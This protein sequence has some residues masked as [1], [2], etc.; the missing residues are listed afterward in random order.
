MEKYVFADGHETPYISSRQN[1]R[2]TSAAKLSDKK[3]R[4]ISGR[5]LCEGVKLTL[6]AAKYGRLCEVYV[7]ESDAE[8][9]RDAVSSAEVAGCEVFVLS[10]PA[11]DK[12]TTEK[13]PQGIISVAECAPFQPAFFEDGNI[14]FLDSIRDPGNLGTII[15]SACAFGNVSVVLYSCADLYNTK[16]V[17]AAMGALFKTRTAVL[18]DASAF[19]VECKKQGRRVLGAALE[20]DSLKLGNYETRCNDVIV[21]GNEGHGISP[22]I[23]EMCDE[24]VLIP[25]NENTES[26]NASVAAS[27]ILWE[28]S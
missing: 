19:F 16:T 13:A 10:D 7:R 23:C 18:N 27:V 15:R 28:Y 8:K 26:L 12:I 1:P 4:E 20:A 2:V 5:F 22:E 17:R 11:F 24:F 21:I 6:E 25:M 9:Y 14:L 3:H